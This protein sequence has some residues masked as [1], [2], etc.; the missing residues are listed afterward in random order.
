MQHL[1]FQI[2]KRRTFTSNMIVITGAAGFIGSC[3]IRKLNDEN[4]NDLVLVDDFSSAEKE[5]NTAEKKITSKINRED[6]IEWLKQNH[7]FVQFIF[8]IGARTDTTEFDYSVFEKL[9]VQYSKD[10][11]N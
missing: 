9:N 2:L 7:R 10:V 6:F 11:W 4:F 8:H 1:L 3:L 5:K